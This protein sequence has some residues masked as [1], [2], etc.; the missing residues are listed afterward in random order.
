MF[1]PFS[2]LYKSIITS[3]FGFTCWVLIISLTTCWPKKIWSSDFCKMSR[4]ITRGLWR[5]LKLE[6]PQQLVHE[7]IQPQKHNVLK[8]R[9]YNRLKIPTMNV[10]NVLNGRSTFPSN[11]RRVGGKKKT[12]STFNWLVFYT[13]T[14]IP[15]IEVE[16]TIEWTKHWTCS[17]C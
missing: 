16:C 8:P 9:E 5:Q 6:A 17:T 11:I 10:N 3:L 14:I 7:A 4:V 13:P 12:T 1:M 2:F 15:T